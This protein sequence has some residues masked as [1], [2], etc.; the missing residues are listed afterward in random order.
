MI[1]W[2]RLVLSVVTLGLLSVLVIYLTI[3]SSQLPAVDPFDAIERRLS[4]QQRRINELE[5][6]ID[7]VATALRLERQSADYD[8][9]RRI[10]TIVARENARDR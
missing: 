8:Q 4:V 7:T 3:Y 5:T 9:Q 1:P 10:N 6:R 2:K